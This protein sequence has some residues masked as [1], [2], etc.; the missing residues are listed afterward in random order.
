MKNDF[1]LGTMYWLNPNNS[2]ADFEK[3][4]KSIADNGY[5]LVRIIVWWELVE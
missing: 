2:A 4:C 1:C 5:S 3:D